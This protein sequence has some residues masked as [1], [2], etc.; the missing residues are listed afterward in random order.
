MKTERM[1]GMI[2]G[3]TTGM[4]RKLREERPAENLY[5]IGAIGKIGMINLIDDK[6]GLM[7][8][9]IVW[10]LVFSHK[11]NIMACVYRRI[12]FI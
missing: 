5:L 9:K 12:L 4:R 8:K 7:K 1:D 3:M 11:L 6:F 2:I 10:R